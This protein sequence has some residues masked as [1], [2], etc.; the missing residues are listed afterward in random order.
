MQPLFRVYLNGV[1]INDEP[2][3]LIDTELTIKRDED[4]KGVFFSFTSELTFYGDGYAALRDIRDSA[5]GCAQVPCNIEYKCSETRGYEVLYEAIIPLGSTDV[6][7]DDYNCQ[8][9]T[10]LENADFSNLLQS[11]GDLPIRINSPRTI[12]NADTLASITENT[13]RFIV[14]FSG[15][16]ISPGVPTYLFTDALQQVLSYLSDNSITLVADPVYST[17]FTPQVLQFVFTDP[18]AVGDSMVLTFT[19]FYNQEYTVA[20]TAPSGSA[21]FIIDEF[22]TRLLHF[23]NIAS[24]GRT[25][26][27]EKANKIDF[28]GNTVTNYAPWKT[29]SI[30][31]N[32]GAKLA[33]VTET[34]SYQYGL[35]NLAITTNTQIQEQQAEVYVT[36]N[37]L[38]MHA[39]QMNNMGFQ[40]VKSGSGYNFNLT[41]LPD[42]LDD[43]STGIILN[44]IKDQKV[45]TTGDFNVNSLTTAPGEADAI[46]QPFAWHAQNCY[47]DN[48]KIEGGNY[49]S[50]EFFTEIN[51]TKGQDDTLFFVFLMEGDYTQV[52]PYMLS[53]A[54]INPGIGPTNQTHYNMPYAMPFLIK[55]NEIFFADNTPFS[56]IRIALPDPISTCTNC[57]TATITNENAVIIKFVTTFQYPLTY[58]QVR[59][60]IDNALQYINFTD[61]RNATKK[62]FIKEATIPFKNFIASFELYTD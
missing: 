11:Y 26:Y 3:G 8:V 24:G 51:A 7:W 34:Q 14:D 44:Q 16:L 4:L 47:G 32:G 55:R 27:L 29:W 61:G 20:F 41:F 5:E 46:F 10:R 9:T 31:V 35:K 30:S 50:Q 43:N 2:K 38:L 36:L 37:D 42:L 62:G 13:T 45:K 39:S 6:E 17:L 54:I 59:N 33:S 15:G 40:L 19:N 58:S 1:Y 56:D 22:M 48:A 60:M 53:Y 57:P 49:S 12:N 25:N 52:E 21:A 28:P 23:E 18:P